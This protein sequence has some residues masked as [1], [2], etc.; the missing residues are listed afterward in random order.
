MENA[1]QITMGTQ[2]VKNIHRKTFIGNAHGLCAIKKAYLCIGTEGP[3]I[4]TQKFP[5]DVIYHLPTLKLWEN[6]EISFRLRNITFDRHVFFSRKQ[7]KVKLLNSSTA[8][9]KN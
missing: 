5:H 6:L 3:R 1:A 4:L 8:R 7:K 9:G 2:M